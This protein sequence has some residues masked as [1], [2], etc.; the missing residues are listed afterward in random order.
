[1]STSMHSS[2]GLPTLDLV[3]LDLVVGGDGEKQ[4]AS[5]LSRGASGAGKVIS[6]VAP[7]L[8][9]GM[10]AYE[11][12]KGYDNARARGA[13][14]GESLKEGGL[15]AVNSATFGLSNWVLGRK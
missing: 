10:A 8:K 1:M 4:A 5:W 7:P 13:G 6:K 2:S 12:Y 9:V 14:V 11:G 3:E 15:Q